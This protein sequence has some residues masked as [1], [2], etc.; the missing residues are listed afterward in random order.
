MTCRLIFFAEWSE[1]PAALKKPK[2][3]TYKEEYTA[4]YAAYAESGPA[5]SSSAFDVGS[6]MAIVKPTMIEGTQ[7]STFFIYSVSFIAIILPTPSA[8]LCFQ[9]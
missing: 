4:A 3:S 2:L 6:A 1:S 7:K 5:A 9:C 8:V